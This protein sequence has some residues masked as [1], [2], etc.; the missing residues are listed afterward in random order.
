MTK[1]IKTDAKSSVDSM[2]NQFQRQREDA[3]FMDYDALKPASK[4]AEPKKQGRTN[5]I[6]EQTRKSTVKTEP[7]SSKTHVA[8]YLD[9]ELYKD[10]KGIRLYHPEALD[11]KSISAYFSEII[12][13]QIQEIKDKVEQ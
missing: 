2:M 4:V 13:Q 11:G 8:L 6:A 7:K 5:G 1:V 10:I 12:E 9:S 3:A